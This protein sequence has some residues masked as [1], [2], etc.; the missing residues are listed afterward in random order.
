MALKEDMVKGLCVPNQDIVKGLPIRL[1][2]VGDSDVLLVIE[3][4]AAF[5]GFNMTIKPSGWL[6]MGSV[7]KMK[8]L[9]G[10]PHSEDV[11]KWL[12]AVLG[13]FPRVVDAVRAMKSM[14]VSES[15]LEMHD[16]SVDHIDV[17]FHA[18][19]VRLNFSNGQAF[20]NKAIELSPHQA[21]KL[22]GLLQGSRLK[23][24]EVHQRYSKSRRE[25]IDSEIA[26]LKAE[27]SKLR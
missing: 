6:D 23:V 13:G 7:G 1:D 4:T 21:E 3:R 19:G 17:C 12:D 22:Y 14:D 24:E 9:R 8:A 10:I 15:M 18:N 2:R 27:R 5:P 11:V 16:N 26:R 20:T 25:E